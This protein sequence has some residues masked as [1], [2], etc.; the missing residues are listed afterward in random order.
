MFGGFV[1]ELLFGFY[2]TEMAA[3]VVLMIIDYVTGIACA[4][5]AKKLSSSTG[6]HG[7]LKKVCIMCLVVVGGI[8]DVIIGSNIAKLGVIFFYIGNEG[9]SILENCVKLGVTTPEFIASSLEQIM[10]DKR[11]EE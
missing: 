4:F 2:G 10:N 6:F 11:R 3:L 8:V 1:Y 9:L 7:I 5:K